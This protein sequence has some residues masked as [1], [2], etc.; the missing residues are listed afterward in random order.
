MLK[1]PENLKAVD[2]RHLVQVLV[3]GADQNLPPEAVDGVGSL[4]FL[5]QPVEHADAVEVLAPGT[6]TAQREQGAADRDLVG[7]AEA[8]HGEERLGKMQGRR[9][10]SA[11]HHGDS[12]ARFDEVELAEEL[13][14]V[15]HPHALVEVQQI[16]TAAQQD[17][18]AIIN[19]FSNFLA[20]GGHRVG[21]GPPSQEGARLVKIDL[22]AVAPQGCGGRQTRQSSTGNQYFGH[23][24]KYP[25]PK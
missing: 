15:P 18:L 10:T 19:G 12:S 14:A 9:Q 3:D 7:G 5:Q 1:K 20:S 13:Y 21:R 23:S 11:L 25:K 8:L 17:V 6:F 4:A 22:P 16:G 24:C 2:G